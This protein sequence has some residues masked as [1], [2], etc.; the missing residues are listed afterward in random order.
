MTRDDIDEL[1]YIAPIAN[2]ESILQLGILS[3]NRA[4][5]V[6]HESV[7]MEE[8]QSLR[9]DK[10]I[11]GAGK[12]HD[13]VNLYFDAH[14]PMLSTVRGR[15]TEIC[16]L[17]VE[18]GVLDLPGVIVSDRNAAVGY[19]KFFPAAI[20]LT[21]LDRDR[22]F[23]QYWTHQDPMEYLRRKSAKCA[24]VLVPGRVEASFIVGAYVCNESV[25]K[26]W[27]ESGLPLPASVKPGL[28]F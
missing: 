25:V 23:A 8:I 18:A 27:G 7:A 13:F 26:R 6:L 22:I 1:Y 12:L 21:K 17:R 9:K 5:K 28:F 4:V 15:N 11:P 10:R 3:H 14:N 24:E 19:A 16:V 2:V 20:G